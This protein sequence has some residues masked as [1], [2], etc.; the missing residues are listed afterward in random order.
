MLSQ[1]FLDRVK[2]AKPVLMDRWELDVKSAD[3]MTKEELDWVPPSLAKTKATDA[4][5]A[6]ASGAVAGSTGGA[7]AG[8][9]G[10]D[11]SGTESKSVVVTVPLGGGGGI[12]G[13]ME[14]DRLRGVFC[15]YWSIG[16]DASVLFDFH[17]ERKRNPKRFTGQLKNKSIYMVKGMKR[18]CGEPYLRG[19]LTIELEGGN[20][21]IV[22][23]RPLVIPKYVLRVIH[24]D[25]WHQHNRRTTRH[26]CS[27]NHFRTL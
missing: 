17:R 10:G 8:D 6:E 16:C 13:G 18:M 11:E 14:G 20:S 15:N 23:R 12:G 24:I 26:S 27:S 2:R 25:V 21:T 5:T 1:P 7:A 22:G 9:S 19:C 4:V 3:D